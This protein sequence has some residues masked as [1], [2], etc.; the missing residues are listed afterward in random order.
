MIRRV[1]SKGLDMLLLPL[2]KGRM[3]PYLGYRPRD[4]GFT[5]KISISSSDTLHG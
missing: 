4:W 2:T 5:L 1:R 3:A